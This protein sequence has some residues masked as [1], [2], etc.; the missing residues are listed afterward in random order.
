MATGGLYQPLQQ[1]GLDGF[2]HLMGER[3]AKM[4]ASIQLLFCWTSDH[5]LR[6]ASRALHCILLD[7]L[8]KF[9]FETLV[10][11]V[12]SKKIDKRVCG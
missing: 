10:A 12:L 9:F 5:W 2:A 6:P 8:L 1:P 3:S 11:C 4:E 7:L